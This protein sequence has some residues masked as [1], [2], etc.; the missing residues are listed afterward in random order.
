MDSD[1]ELT[2][3]IAPDVLRSLESRGFFEIL[4]DR[5][6][7]KDPTLARTLCQGTLAISTASLITCG[8]DEQEITDIVAVLA[9]RGGYCDCEVLYNV[10]EESRLKSEY[11]KPVAS[12][13]KP[14]HGHGAQESPRNLVRIWI[15]VEK[16]EV[17]YPESQDWEDLWG[18]PTSEGQLVIDSVPFFAKGVARRD[19]VTGVLSEDGFLAVGKITK[20][21][22]HSTFRIWLAEHLIGSLDQVVSDLKRMDAVVEVTLQRLLAIDTGPE[23]E[24]TIWDYL[25]EGKKRAAWELQ[26]GYSP[27]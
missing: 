3:V 15:R 18:Q 12:K 16:D 24:S 5:M 27:D 4:D 10:A 11:W 8:Y 17:G 13:R 1:N 7:P 6:C 22:G 25:E 14:L 9:A 2:E 21:G 20:R 19:Q 26:V 23:Q